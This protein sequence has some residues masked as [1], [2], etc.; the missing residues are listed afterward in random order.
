MRVFQ[1]AEDLGNLA[2]ALKEAY[3][4]AQ[5]YLHPADYQAP[6][7]MLFPL[8][9]QLAAVEPYGEGDRLQLGGLT[10]SV[11]HTPGHS[12]G[13]VTLRCGQALFCG[14]TLFAGS[15]GRTDFP[16]GSMRDMM[17]SLAR[18]GALEGD[19]HLYPGHMEDST[20]S[21]ERMDNPY[22]LQAMGR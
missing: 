11:L 12:Q 15:C 1:N 6:D 22:L 5:V 7:S 16:G 3:P 2:A 8:R 19:F 9:T 17:A 21:R 20:L 14:D 4:Q 18:L 13:S 10:F